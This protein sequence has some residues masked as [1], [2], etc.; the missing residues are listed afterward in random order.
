[1]LQLPDDP[2]VS[3]DLVHDPARPVTDLSAINHLVVQVDDLDAT[4]ADNLAGLGEP[5]RW[6]PA[7]DWAISHQAAHK[8]LVNEQDFVTAQTLRATRPTEDGT[9]RTYLLTGLLRC[10]LCRRRMDA[11]WVHDRPGYRCRH[12]HTSAR[13][14][15]PRGPSN[16]YRPT[17]IRQRRSPPA[18]NA[19]E[20]RGVITCPRSIP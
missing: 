3:L 10:D 11:H 14:T 12:G 20:L 8:A 17:G 13:P 7:Q 5:R 1:M 6:N 18:P 2:F 15:E 9:T 4:I 16:R 19:N